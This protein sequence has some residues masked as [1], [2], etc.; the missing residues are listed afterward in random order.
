M[1]LV[2]IA[3]RVHPEFPLVV[4]SNRDE[5][6]ERPTEPLHRWEVSPKIIGGKDLKA[7]G[8]WLGVSSLGKLAFLTNVRNLKKPPHPKPKSRGGLVLDFLN[9]SKDLNS[10]KYRE[11]V[12]RTAQ[13]YEGFNLF[14]FDGEVASFV[15]GDPLESEILEPGFYAVSN[16]NWKTAWPKTEKLKSSVKQA[17]DAITKDS[18]W[19]STVSKEFFRFLADSELVKE[20]SL[21]PDTG[22]GMEKE[23]YL[24]SIRIRVPGYGTRASTLV[25]YGKESV[26]VVERTFSD[27]LSNEFTERREVLEFNET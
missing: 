25:F 24:S 9:S 21:L 8:T 14:V 10:D 20:D 2:V 7:G 11:E 4:V 16:A 17:F 13:D 1:C 5:F 22:L 6:F 18:R 27:P 19:I 23:R 26:E 15:G 3:Y 12:L